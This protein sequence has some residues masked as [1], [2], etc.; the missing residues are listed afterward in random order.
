MSQKKYW[1]SSRVFGT[2]RISVFIETLSCGYIFKFIKTS[3]PTVINLSNRK[4]MR[5]ELNY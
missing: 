5:I 3:T 1:T 2:F 4:V